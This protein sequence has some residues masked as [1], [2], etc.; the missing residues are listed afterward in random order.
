M[1][2]KMKTVVLVAMIVVVAVGAIHTVRPNSGS[3]TS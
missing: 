2:F 3:N 1:L